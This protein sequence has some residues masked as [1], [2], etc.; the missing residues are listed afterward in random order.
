MRPGRLHQELGHDLGLTLGRTQAYATYTSSRMSNSCSFARTQIRHSLIGLHRG[1]R[2]EVAKEARSSA[3]QRPSVQPPSPPSSQKYF[4]HI[5]CK[6]LPPPA[7]IKTSYKC[8][9][10]LTKSL[11][12]KIMQLYK[13]YPFHIEL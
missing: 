1:K 11:A 10:P 13:N 4:V 9:P 12:K 7:S 5:F 6:D 2:P 8:V 3:K